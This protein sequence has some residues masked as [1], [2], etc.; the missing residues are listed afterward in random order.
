M[1]YNSRRSQV[2][3]RNGM[4]AT[5]Q[6][7]AAMA[8]LRML[9]NG[10]SA[11]DGAVAAAAALNVVEP[12]STGIGGDLFALVWDASKKR[13]SAL[14]ASGRASA[15][16]SIRDLEQHGYSYIP[17]DSAFGVT[18]PGTVDGWYTLLSAFGSMSLAEVLAPAIEYAESGYPVSPVIADDFAKATPKLLRYPSGG[19]L[20]L[21]NNA[22]RTGEVLR[23]P[24]L[25]S[26]LNIIAEGG[27]D[28][29]YRGPLAQKIAGY[30][31]EKG[32]WLSVQDFANHTS[33]WDEPINTTY[34]GIT[35]WECPPN[36]QGLNTLMALNIVEGLDIPS[37]GFQSVAGSHHLIEAMR[38]AF[39]D[40]LHYIADPRHS[41]IPLKQLLSKDYARDRRSLISP[42]RAMKSVAYNPNLKDSD[43]VYVTCVDGKGNACSL[44]NSLFQGFGTGLV[45]PGTGI[46]LQNR[47]MSFSMNPEHPNALSPG[48]RPF[49]TIIPG[50]ATKGSDLWLSYGVMGGFHQAQ[51]H[52][53]VLVNMIDF[54]LDPQS[55]LDARRFNVNLDDSTSLEQDFSSDVVQGLLA[56]GHNIPIGSGIQGLF[57]GGGQIIQRNAETGVLAAGSDPRKDGCA[58]GW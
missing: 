40:G 53:Q 48:K 44:I 50:M 29:F 1:L 55:A 15:A 57:F 28:A 20:L 49:H 34:R 33:T 30:V 11:V 2:L 47:G 13:I 5:S 35:C 52:L 21:N 17:S 3:S 6:P 51:G 25:A 56:K 16:S 14:N 18:V 10:G 19:E 31:Q 54:D 12:G 23:L 24:E 7:L 38:L 27:P 41:S 45:V 22:P 9:M 58:M 42:D 36:G 37:M 4:V 46:A 32:G 26:S 39:A 43:T 8:G